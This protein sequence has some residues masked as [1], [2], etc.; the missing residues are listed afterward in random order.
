[1]K[2]H[3]FSLFILIAVLVSCKKE[4]DYSVM[5]LTTIQYGVVDIFMHGAGSVSIDW[6]DGSA[7]E[8]HTL[9][10]KNDNYHGIANNERTHFSHIY[11]NVST[12]TIK[13][14]GENITHLGCS[15]IGLK[16]IDVRNNNALI[17][18]DCGGNLLTDIDVSSNTALEELWCGSNQLSNLDLSSVT[19]LKT[20]YCHFNQLS[21]LD[22]SRA[23][24]LSTLICYSNQLEILDVS[25]NTSLFL[26]N[27]FDNLLH[28]LNVSNNP[29][30]Q[31]LLCEKNR[32]TNLDVSSIVDLSYFL[33]YDNQLTSIRFGNHPIL[34]VVNC[35]GN[36]LEQLDMNKNNT[37]L[38]GNLS[39]QSNKLSEEAL[40]ALFW[41]LY[42]KEWGTVYIHD[43]PGTGAFADGDV[44]NGWTIDTVKPYKNME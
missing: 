1:M 13:I 36:Q 31:Y 18:L 41:S 6:G 32:L 33:C 34:M 44:I 24:V 16:D 42:Y 15:G 29:K 26:L 22:L 27:C 8:T 9:H 7:R 14:E 20:L 40:H 2:G 39:C 3:F 10:P 37:I 5:F 30:I 25:R 4:P 43:N 23:T 28:T 19:A 21:Y 11:Q 38:F 17:F 12:H 35:S